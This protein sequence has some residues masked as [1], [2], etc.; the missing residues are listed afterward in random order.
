MTSCASRR[1]R[2]WSRSTVTSTR[3]KR[4]RP[5]LAKPAGT[6]GRSGPIRANGSACNDSWPIVRLFRP[7][8]AD[9]GFTRPTRAILPDRGDQYP[10]GVPNL[11]L[12]RRILVERHVATGVRLVIPDVAIDRRRVAG[13]HQVHVVHPVHQRPSQGLRADGVPV[14]D[15]GEAPSGQM[16]RVVP[17]RELERL[18]L[19]RSLPAVLVGSGL[20]PSA[21]TSRSIISLSTLGAWYQ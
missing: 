20:P 4:S 3:R 12:Q 6:S 1:A 8:I 2:R 10:G 15:D 7:G 14:H 13:L 11:L 19:R 16:T 21:Q 5:W 9:V 17:S 18:G